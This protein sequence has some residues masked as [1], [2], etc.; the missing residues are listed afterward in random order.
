MASGKLLGGSTLHN[1][2]YTTMKRTLSSGLLAIGLFY[3]CQEKQVQPIRSNSIF[4]TMGDWQVFPPWTDE[5]GPTNVSLG[6]PI[7]DDFEIIKNASEFEIST[8]LCWTRLSRRE[9]ANLR[10]L[11]KSKELRD[12]LRS[13]NCGVGEGIEIDMGSGE[14]PFDAKFYLTI[15]AKQ[16]LPEL[17]ISEIIDLVK[18]YRVH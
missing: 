16:E 5:Q 4:E 13:H 9:V 18:N 8:S 7:R 11:T 3:S 6:S 14:D 2:T 15:S 10:N 1:I 12:L 17:L